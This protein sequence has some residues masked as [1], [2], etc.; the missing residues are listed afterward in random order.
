M[1]RAH[2]KRTTDAGQP[3]RFRYAWH[4]ESAAWRKLVH[5][6]RYGECA[7]GQSLGMQG[8]RQALAQERGKSGEFLVTE[9]EEER[10]GIEVQLGK[11]LAGRLDADSV[12]GLAPQ[13]IE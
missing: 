7:G 4:E 8:A 6:P 2:E 13:P 12:F 5:E 3:H 11:N 10:S 9:P 1:K